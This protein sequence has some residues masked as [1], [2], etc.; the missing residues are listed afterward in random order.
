LSPLP[1]FTGPGAPGAYPNDT[2]RNQIISAAIMYYVAMEVAHS[3]QLTSTIEGTRQTSY[4]YHHPPGSG[5]NMDQAIINKIDKSGS[6]FNSF[7]IPSV[8]TS[9]DQGTFKLRN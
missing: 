4:G 6:G 3:A 5:S 8:Y 1:Q 7:Y 2:S 9:G